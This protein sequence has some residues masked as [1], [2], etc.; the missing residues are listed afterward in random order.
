[1]DNNL[2]L[3]VPRHYYNTLGNGYQQQYE[4][5]PRIMTYIDIIA[6]KDRAKVNY[7]YEDSHEEYITFTF[8]G[9][10]KDPIFI[11]DI[12]EITLV[13]DGREVWYYEPDGDEVRF[14]SGEGQKVDEW[15]NS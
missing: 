13:V 14:V 15:H 3:K 11:H 5:L 8:P 2:Y 7:T 9:G 10:A 4:N 1:M 12:E 6:S